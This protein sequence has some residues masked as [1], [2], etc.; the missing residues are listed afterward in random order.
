MEISHFDNN[1]MQL[2]KFHKVLS[3]KMDNRDMESVCSV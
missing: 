2:A 1:F 3:E